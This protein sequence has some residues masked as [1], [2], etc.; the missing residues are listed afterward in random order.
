VPA[1]ARPAVGAAAKLVVVGGAG[2]EEDG[3]RIDD[4]VLGIGSAVGIGCSVV[5]VNGSGDVPRDILM[6]EGEAS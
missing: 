3:R 6:I 4:V 2:M 5:V 1:V